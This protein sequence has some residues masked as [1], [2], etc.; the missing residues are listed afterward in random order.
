MK[1]LL[2]ENITPK[3]C[4][5]LEKYGHDVL[6]VINRYGAGKSDKEVFELAIKEQRVLITL[7]GKDFIIFIPPVKDNVEHY[8]FIWLRG[9]YVTM[10]TYEEIMDQIGE[11]LKENSNNVKNTYYA[12]KKKHGEYKIIQQYPKN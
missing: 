5:V 6:H 12:M 9:V 4:A 8:G 2:D 3:S 11:F 7:N 1:V 10:K